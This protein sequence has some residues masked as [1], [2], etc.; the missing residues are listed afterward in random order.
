[1]V[2]KFLIMACVIIA[3]VSSAEAQFRYGFRL[4]ASFVDAKM[5]NAPGYAIVNKSG[6][7]GGIDFEYQ[8]PSSGFAADIAILYDRYN[9]Q[10]KGPDG[11]VGSFGRNHI[12]IPLHVKYKFWLSSFHDLFAPLVYTGPSFLMRLDDNH[13]RAL[14]TNDIQPG[15]DVGIGVDIINFI[16]ITGGYRFGLGNSVKS[17]T[18]CPDATL[19]TNAWNVAATIL[20]DF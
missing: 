19:R 14:S 6:F 2:R 3:A 17:F 7:E 16:Q 10:L 15:W 13:N 8:H 20:F 1:M 5:K 18:G 9:A 4:G 11:N 12:E